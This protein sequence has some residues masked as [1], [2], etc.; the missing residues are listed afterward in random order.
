M[1]DYAS[2][3]I[4]ELKPFDGFTH[5]RALVTLPNR[6]TYQVAGTFDDGF[7]PKAKYGMMDFQRAFNLGGATIRNPNGYG[8]KQ[9]ADT[10]HKVRSD[11]QSAV[12]KALV[13]EQIVT[14]D[15]S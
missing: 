4:T 15:F 6:R 3:T 13:A 2:T 12:I 9:V 5:F 14:P 10:A 8:R 7:Q 1:T 11:L